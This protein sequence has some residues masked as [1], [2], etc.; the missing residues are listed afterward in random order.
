MGVLCG[1]IVN[2]SKPYYNQYCVLFKYKKK[3]GG[4]I[5]IE[6]SL[7]VGGKSEVIYD[8]MLRPANVSPWIEVAVD[9]ERTEQS[10]GRLSYH[11]LPETYLGPFS[12]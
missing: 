8:H 1:S 12:K 5:R 9:L 7:D 6:L 3:A 4:V 10:M 11:A 2:H